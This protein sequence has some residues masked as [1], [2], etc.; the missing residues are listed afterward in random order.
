MN[1]SAR[2]G[3]STQIGF[4][5]ERVVSSAGNVEKR[6]ENRRASLGGK[7][8]HLTSDDM[9]CKFAK[10]SHHCL[11][12]QKCLRRYAGLIGFDD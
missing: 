9:A 8:L 11:L 1:V 5:S 12:P 3:A 2:R 6:M 10:R 7:V 4:V